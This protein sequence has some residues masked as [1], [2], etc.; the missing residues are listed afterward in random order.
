M[1]LFTCTRAMRNQACYCGASRGFLTKNW[2]SS[3]SIFWG[4]TDF[5]V[6]YEIKAIVEGKWTAQ[7]EDISGQ[8]FVQRST[9]RNDN[10]HRVQPQMTRL[11]LSEVNYKSTKEALEEMLAQVRTA[12]TQLRKQ[13]SNYRQEAVTTNLSS[14][15]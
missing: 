13:E 11:D 3:L 9:Q 15:H 8:A 14:R 12:R 2:T 7:L 4:D 6:V 10:D 5:G 1:G